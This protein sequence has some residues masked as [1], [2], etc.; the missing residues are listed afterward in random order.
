MTYVSVKSTKLDLK[1]LSQK[2]GLDKPPGHKDAFEGFTLEERK[3]AKEKLKR[4]KDPQAEVE[5]KPPLVEGHTKNKKQKTT[6]QTQPQKKKEP[7]IKTFQEEVP[8]E[9][10]IW[11]KYKFKKEYIRL[12]EVKWPYIFEAKCKSGVLEVTIIARWPPGGSGTYSHIRAK[13]FFKL[14]FEHFARMGNPVK[15]LDGMFAWDNYLQFKKRLIGPPALSLEEA[16][17]QAPTAKFW[18]DHNGVRFDKVISVKDCPDEGTHGLVKF[19]VIQSKNKPP[20]GQRKENSWGLKE[21]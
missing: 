17:L 19:V 18:V 8:D 14:M 6:I 21:K 4:L 10:N 3:A 1:N 20:Y 11:K 5:I 12:E 15:K 13:K 7:Q 16:V 2:A 9:P